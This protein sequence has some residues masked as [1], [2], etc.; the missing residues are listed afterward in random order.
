MAGSTIA[1][2]LS[3]LS[4]WHKIYY[5][6][7][8]TTHFMVRRVLSGM[9]KARPG[10]SLRPALS[11]LDLASMKETLKL[12]SWTPYVKRLIWAMILL[13]FHAFLRA[14]EMTKSTNTLM[15]HQVSLSS[16]SL[17]IHFVRFKHSKG[18]RVTIKVKRQASTFCPLLALKQYLELRGNY[19]GYLFCHVDGSGLSYAWY[20][21]HFNELVKLSGLDCDL[22]THS[23]RI[24]AATYA[25]AAGFSEDKI[26]RMGRWA[27]SAVN[28]YI[29]LP[30]IC[31]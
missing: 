3:A 5:K 17:K 25:A 14:G 22:S 8:P 11:V 16:S 4:F 29:K 28:S 12:I 9:K 23:A 31:F 6:D 10:G 26:K 7:D 1:T 21:K 2:K 15:L 13:A 18:R 19:K 24:G 20:R 30:V 27:S